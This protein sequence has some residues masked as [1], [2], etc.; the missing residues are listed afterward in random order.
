MEIRLQHLLYGYS[1][2]GNV[3][4]YDDLT[5]KTML[6]DL[7][8]PKQGAVIMCDK[9]KYIL[10]SNCDKKK[11]ILKSKCH[12]G[13][14]ME[15]LDTQ[16]RRTE[17][18][19][20]DVTLEVEGEL[21]L[22]HKAILAACSG[23]FN[24]K[25]KESTS[26]LIGQRS[27]D[28]KLFHPM[29]PA[30]RRRKTVS[31]SHYGRSI[32]VKMIPSPPTS[33]IFPPSPKSRSFAVKSPR[34]RQTIS[35]PGFNPK[36]FGQLLDY[37]YT[38]ELCIT[39]EN[40]VD[41]LL[42]SCLLQ[43]HDVIKACMYVMLKEPTWKS[44]AKRSNV[45]SPARFSRRRSGEKTKGN[46]NPHFRRSIE[47]PEST[48]VS[49]SV[50]S[51]KRHYEESTCLESSG[52]KMTSLS[53]GSHTESENREKV[54]A[55]YSGVQSKELWEHC[56]VP[57]PCSPV[58]CSK[59]APE[60]HCERSAAR[61]DKTESDKAMPILPDA[62]MFMPPKL[63][64][65]CGKQLPIQKARSFE[66]R[67]PLAAGRIRTYSEGQHIL[68]PA[69]SYGDVA[70]ESV[71]SGLAVSSRTDATVVQT[72]R[73]RPFSLHRQKP[74]RSDSDPRLDQS[75]KQ[76]VQP[77]HD[78]IT[79][80]AT[81]LPQY[82]ID[83]R[84]QASKP[85]TIGTPPLTILTASQNNL[86]QPAFD[87]NRL[88]LEQQYA[89]ALADQMCQP[90]QLFH[91]H[92]PGLYPPGFLVSL[93][94]QPEVLLSP[95]T[96][97]THC[98]GNTPQVRPVLTFPGTATSFH[99]QTLAHNLIPKHLKLVEPLYY[100]GEPPCYVSPPKSV[101]HSETE[102]P[103]YDV[104]CIKHL[105]KRKLMS[106]AMADSG[107]DT[108]SVEAMSIDSGVVIESSKSISLQANSIE[109]IPSVNHQS[110]PVSSTATISPLSLSTNEE[111]ARQ[112]QCVM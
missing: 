14:V 19:T 29:P 94:Q 80:Q 76:V 78:D 11:Y 87:Y 56:I 22:A 40:I 36:I 103:R 111:I 73:R 32:S 90:S 65:S 109:D 1:D 46:P 7:R 54:L 96:L 37:M 21:L 23:F 60:R 63:G 97:Y 64:L 52:I 13:E 86:I 61:S 69:R 53:E 3:R 33:P 58:D 83:L 89:A 71:H 49:Q 67:S 6:H 12:I 48:A 24:E 112:Q 75:F 42:M 82:P 26:T 93:P 8:K 106:A 15:Q 84:S 72:D 108:E 4:T 92:I 28:E 79:R 18:S 41:L 59:L 31:E 2:H 88:F 38:V 9:K 17:N 62:R 105:K 47:D 98:A 107:T 5:I 77:S 100:A 51:G 50:K 68:P 25:L 74:V 27:L 102:R 110:K 34:R 16:R 104:S 57:R 43:V 44:K 55:R 91:P 101:S 10:K 30:K 45:K 20:C 81:T 99:E 85:P 70:H 39:E 95:R 66:R 35:L